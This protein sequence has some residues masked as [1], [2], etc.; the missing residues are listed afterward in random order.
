MRIRA[1]ATVEFEQEI[2][3]RSDESARGWLT[4]D[5]ETILDAWEN[6]YENVNVSHIMIDRV[7]E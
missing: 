7:D 3:D 6:G 1:V 4:E 5:I 2:G